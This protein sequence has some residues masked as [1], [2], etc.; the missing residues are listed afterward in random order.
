M[1]VTTDTLRD[2]HRIHRQVADLQN[3]LNK[4]PH[5]VAA[6]QNNVA[7]IEEEHANIK[8][9]LTKAR[10]L[11][12][13]K[14]LQL[15]QREDRLADLRSK[16]NACSSNREYQTLQ[17]QIAADIQANSV[18]SDEILEILERIDQQQEQLQRSETDLTK[19]R[20]LLEELRQRVDGE[21]AGLEDEL[22]RVSQELQ[23]A[24]AALPGEIRAEYFRITRA[25]GEDAL[26]PV[27][28]N[29]CGSC[30]HIL[31]AQTMNELSLGVLVFCK[32]CGTLLYAP[33]DTSPGS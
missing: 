32:S 21:R 2:L 28:G 27:E 13:S 11:A 17:E 33:E 20:A 7:S 15:R 4:G 5:Q 8:D 23:Q 25:R 14:Q 24:E 10:V 22:A 16:L 1:S 6:R 31:S 9:T 30:F 18:L 26:A 12:D 19:S 29:T 3:R